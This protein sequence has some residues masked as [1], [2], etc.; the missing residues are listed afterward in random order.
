MSSTQLAFLLVLAATIIGSFG[1]LL[2]KMASKSIKKNLMSFF[3]NKFL[4]LGG[5]LYVLSTVFF[6][7]ALKY[8]DLSFVYPMTSL[9]YVWVTLLSANF[10]G[11]KVTYQKIIGI[12]S[13]ICGI[14]IIGFG[15]V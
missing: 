8:G 11:E 10:L 5:S 9:T 7:P 12:G 15:S 4:Y 6:I 13:I 2:F 1:A 3:T 14:T